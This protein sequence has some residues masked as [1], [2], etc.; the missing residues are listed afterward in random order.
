M[1]KHFRMW[2]GVL[3]HRR[4]RGNSPTYALL[5]KPIGAACIRWVGV[6]GYVGLV[7]EN[8]PIKTPNDGRHGIS[9]ANLKI[10]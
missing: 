10:F 4:R 8:Q 6:R 7:F 2:F 1:H 3:V 9:R 5:T